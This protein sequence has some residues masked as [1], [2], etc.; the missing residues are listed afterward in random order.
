MNPESDVG[1]IVQSFAQP[2]SHGTRLA[3]VGRM[4]TGETFAVVRNRFHPSFFVRRSELGDAQGALGSIEFGV[5]ESWWKTLDGAEVAELRFESLRDASVAAER[6]ALRSIRTYEADVKATDRFLM[7]QRIHGSC[8]IVGDYQRGRHVDRVY[9][10]PELAA[11]DWRPTLGVLALDI[12]TD[13]AG[14][15]IRAVSLVRCSLE[16][17]AE[18]REVEPVRC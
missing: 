5:L 2:L 16:V 13:P 4:A 10:D 14:S 17:G 7:D 9:I 8:R 6:L 15:E 3:F 12:E 18:Q 11:C 1:F